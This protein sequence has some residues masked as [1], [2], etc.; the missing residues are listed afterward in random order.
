VVSGGKMKRSSLA[1]YRSAITIYHS[2]LTYPE[3]YAKM[4]L[5]AKK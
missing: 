1:T 5:A 2:P 3:N 4:P